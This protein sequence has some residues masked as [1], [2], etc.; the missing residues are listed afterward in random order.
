MVD[1]E[2][3]KQLAHDRGITISKLEKETGLAN[4]TIR[5]WDSSTPQV[6]SL[7]KVARY[8]K[9]T[10]EELLYDSEANNKK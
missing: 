3:I 2:K 5:K 8:F 9:T 10:V 1:L 4:A 6:D 7:I